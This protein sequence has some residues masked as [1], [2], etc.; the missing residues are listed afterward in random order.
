VINGLPAIIHKGDRK[1]IQSNHKPTIQFWLSVFSIYR[2]IE[3]GYNLKLEPITDPFMGDT[4]KL[5]HI[6]DFIEKGLFS[7]Y[8]KTLSGYNN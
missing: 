4:D 1:K 7:N 6:E 2:V 5:R 3:T 8:F